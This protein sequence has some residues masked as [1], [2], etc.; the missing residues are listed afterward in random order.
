MTWTTD[1]ST[2]DPSWVA[3]SDT[4][5]PS[6]GSSSATQESWRRLSIKT[7]STGGVDFQLK[8][9]DQFP[10]KVWDHDPLKVI[11]SPQEIP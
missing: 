11:D 9:N 2:T 5:D 1:S 3:D 4:T 10:D 6:W 7:D 8:V